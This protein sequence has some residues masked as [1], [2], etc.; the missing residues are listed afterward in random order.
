MT[1]TIWDLYEEA[2]LGLFL[3]E[4]KK[5][6]RA[7]DKLTRE[8]FELRFKRKPRQDPDYFQKWLKRIKTKDIWEADGDSLRILRKLIRKYGGHVTINK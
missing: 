7:L 3:I 6:K 1:K 2:R 4:H 5:G 8:F